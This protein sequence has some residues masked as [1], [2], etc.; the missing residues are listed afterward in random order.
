ME[1]RKSEAPKCGSIL[2]DQVI[3]YGRL[4]YAYAERARQH[5]GLERSQVRFSGTERVAVP[6]ALA[7]G[8]NGP[9]QRQRHRT[10][11]RAA[12]VLRRQH[13]GLFPESFAMHARCPWLLW[14]ASPAAACLFCFS[15]DERRL[16]VCQYFLGHESEQHGACLAALRASF[17]PYTATQVDVTEIEKLKDIFTRTI[18]FLEEKG[19]AKVPYPQ[20]FL[21]TAERVK[22]EVEQLRAAPDCLPPCGFQ[23]EARHYK[24]SSCSFEDCQLPIDC[25]IQ[26]IHKKEGDVTLLSCEV[27][28]Q[29]PSDRTFSWKFAKGVRTDDLFLFQDLNFGVSSSLLIRPTQGSHHGTFVCQMAEDDDVLIRKYFYV[30]VTEKRL[31]LEK[32]LQEMFK[33]I[34]NPPPEAGPEEVEKRKPTLKEMLSEPNALSN[35]NVILI[36]I[37]IALSSMLVTMAGMTIYQWATGTKA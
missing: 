35:K 37:G 24:C 28:F 20:A 9:V 25:P 33:V 27:R 29:T 6:A 31:G 10:K 17:Q 13:P 3:S 18:F 14:L 1:N 30:N 32:E 7:P 4:G 11:G 23:I 26:D 8:T 21:E 22:K 36:I 16:R 34:L 12:A 5:K 2:V 15:N 19:I